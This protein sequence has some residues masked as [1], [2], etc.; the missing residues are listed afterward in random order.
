[1]EVFGRRRACGRILRALWLLR[2]VL[3][4]PTSLGNVHLRSRYFGFGKFQSNV[5]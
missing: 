3:L 2:L 1:M 5:V 4:P